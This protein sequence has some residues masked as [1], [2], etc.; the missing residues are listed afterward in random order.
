[1]AVA[2]LP[3]PD[4]IVMDLDLLSDSI[5]GRVWNCAKWPEPLLAY[6]FHGAG[7]S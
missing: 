1:M 5:D 3:S 4:A 6:C 7:Y 2:K